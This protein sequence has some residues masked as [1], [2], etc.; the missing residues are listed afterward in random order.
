MWHFHGK[1]VNRLPLCFRYPLDDSTSEGIYVFQSIKE[2]LIGLIRDMDV[3]PDKTSV[4]LVR[5]H[6]NPTVEF[7]SVFR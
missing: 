7:N 4:C 6:L 3:G 1:L 5:V 2:F